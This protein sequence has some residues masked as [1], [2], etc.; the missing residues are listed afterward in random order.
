MIIAARMF[1]ATRGCL[2]TIAARMPSATKGMPDDRSSKTKAV[3]TTD[4]T[5][6]SKVLCCLMS[7]MCSVTMQQGDG[8]SNKTCK[9]THRLQQSDSSRSGDSA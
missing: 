5:Y 6:K 8:C 1:S 4:R 3:H 9:R 2:M 7:V